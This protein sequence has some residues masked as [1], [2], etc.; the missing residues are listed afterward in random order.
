VDRLVGLRQEC[1]VA[2]A[3]L[4][5]GFDVSR[6]HAFRLTCIRARGG[7]LDGHAFKRDPQFEDF[8]ESL[9]IQWG[10]VDPL[11]RFDCYETLIL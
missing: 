2:V 3:S 5:A 4:D 7:K 11:A 9:Q 8:L 6:S 10:D 1:A